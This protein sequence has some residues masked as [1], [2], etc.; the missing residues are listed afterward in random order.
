MR[1]IIATMVFV[2]IALAGCVTT[3][4]AEKAATLEDTAAKIEVAALSC[5]ENR[6]LAKK[7]VEAEAVRYEQADQLESASK[8]LTIMTFIPVVNIFAILANVGISMAD[9]STE[10]LYLLGRKLT[11]AYLEKCT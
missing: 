8:G 3:E 4:R 10:Q 1:K 9:L 11:N 6:T 7:I 5:E 2:G